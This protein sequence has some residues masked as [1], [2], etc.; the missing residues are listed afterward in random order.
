MCETLQLGGGS[1]IVRRMTDSIFNATDGYFVRIFEN[2]DFFV[3]HIFKKEHVK[4]VT[5]NSVT[6]ITEGRRL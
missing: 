5:S 1:T 3:K 2:I 6:T 4:K